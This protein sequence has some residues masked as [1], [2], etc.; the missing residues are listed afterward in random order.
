MTKANK[1]TLS[2][3]G[4]LSLDELA[5]TISDSLRCLNKLKH[6]YLWVGALCVIQ[7]DDDDKRAQIPTMAQI[8]A[9][10]VVTL[11]AASAASA[12]GGLRGVGSP[13]HAPQ[14]HVS[15]KRGALMRSC[16]DR[17]SE[18]ERD[19]EPRGMWEHHN[20]LR[21]NRWNSRGW[22]F[23]ESMFSRWCLI[24]VKGRCTGSVKVPHSVKTHTWRWTRGFVSRV[25]GST[26]RLH[27]QIK[28]I[29]D[30]IILSARQQIYQTGP[31]V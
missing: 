14:H 17:P 20:Y 10:A 9:N 26:Y 6:K 23:Q 22:T 11:L 7:D 1:Q 27:A 29:L 24:F 4:G 15:L 3:E 18:L 19:A 25:L 16:L 5:R 28:R 12:E 31:Y 2:S 13:R 8:Y 30:E 21:S